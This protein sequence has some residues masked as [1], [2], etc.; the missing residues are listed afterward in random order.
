MA[1][2]EQKTSLRRRYV[3]V[4]GPSGVYRPFDGTVAT[5]LERLVAGGRPGTE[6]ATGSGRASA[7]TTAPMV[8]IAASPEPRMRPDD[9]L[10]R[11]TD[12]LDGI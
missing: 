9:D 6:A 12:P 4:S 2:I 8:A 7:R 11:P 5:V 10:D 3:S 1:W